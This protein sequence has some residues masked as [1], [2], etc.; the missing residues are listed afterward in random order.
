MTMKQTTSKVR[1]R[2]TTGRPGFTLLELLIVIAIIT[3][4]SVVTVISVGSIA[5]DVN[6]STGINRVTATL[7]SARAE[8]IRSNT[9]VLV[10]FRMVKDLRRPGKAAQVEMA[11]S[12][13]TGE[14]LSPEQVGYE[15]GYGGGAHSER[16]ELVPRI[17]PQLLPAGIKVGCS[18]ADFGLVNNG[19]EVWCF[20]TSGPF[21]PV[22]DD[23]D[24]KIDYFSSQDK[25]EM[26]GVLFG[27]DGQLLTRNT[28][29]LT[30]G[31]VWVCKW[32]D[33]NNDGKL[34]RATVLPGDAENS[35][36]YQNDT[37][38]EP[39]MNMAQF[40]VV[41]DE[42]RAKEEVDY[43]LWSGETSA[44]AHALA[45]HNELGVWVN[46]KSDRIHFNR[47]TGM[48]EWDGG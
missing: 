35:F 48:A 32:I 9:P 6:L 16:Y 28:Q 31:G 42:E 17:P 33:F 10:S 26:I 25:G 34:E 18:Y 38:D 47:Y 2:I 40:L 27:P 23:S 8:A 44:V 1:P 24:G 20:M 11:V 7:G 41:Y 12:R 45:R 15:V 4:L 14:F 37:I 46:E 36:F 21:I 19:E 43:T 30:A 3:V 29:S 39:F 22:D 13:W 5:R